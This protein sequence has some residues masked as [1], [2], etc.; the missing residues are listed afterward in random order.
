MNTYRLI[1]LTALP[2][3]LARLVQTLGFVIGSIMVARLGHDVLAA[4][5]I[6]NTV[7][8]ALF[9][10]CSGALFSLAQ[11]IA[12]NYADKD[13]SAISQHLI[14]GMYFAGFLS[15]LVVVVFYH[16]EE[17]LVFFG[18]PT[19]IIILVKEYYLWFAPGVLPMLLTTALQ[20]CLIGCHRQIY[21]FKY[22]VFRLILGTIL[23]YALI[24]GKF[25][26]V[27]MGYKGLGL[28]I[29]LASWVGFIGLLVS[30]LIRYSRHIDWRQFL[31][32][33][34]IDRKI[35]DIIKLGFPIGLQMSGEIVAISLATLLIG[36]FGVYALAA[37][38]ITSQ[39]MLIVTMVPFGLS[40]GITVLISR[41]LG[42]GNEKYAI[43][44]RNKAI[45]LIATFTLIIAII[46]SLFPHELSQVFIHRYSRN[47]YSQIIS[48]TTYFFYLLAIYQIF[49]GI[50]NVVAGVLYGYAQTLVTMVYGLGAFWFIG[51]P[52]GYILAFKL[53]YGVIA[54]PLSLTLAVS[55][56]CVLS[57]GY[58]FY[59]RK[60]VRTN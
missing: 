48:I 58:C 52:L 6:A 5:A 53:G 11:L 19:S 45:F 59:W 43:I 25:G 15:I 38:Q 44:L 55:I 13:Y 41:A 56:S 46:Y 40:H 20:E 32:F 4:S 51:I 33:L 14:Q 16:I 8:V 49:D 27:A 50:R 10:F 34:K 54:I 9:T 35:T 47:E 23:G 24:F 28:S 37:Q 12:K 3:I 31:N 17:I 57:L 2:I 7:S 26:V 18:E 21:I 1:I 60:N 39:Y 36:K 30:I 29:T 22:S 42:E